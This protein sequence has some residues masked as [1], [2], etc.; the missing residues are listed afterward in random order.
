MSDYITNV[1][2]LDEAKECFLTYAE[3]VL[4]DR[5]IPNAED[6]LLS[7][8]RK[9]LWTCE[10]VLNLNSKSKYKKSASIVGSTLSTSY[11]HGDSACYGAL[12]KLAQGY[13]MRY[14]LIDGEGNL[15]TQ[16]GNGM[17]ASQRYTNS[18]PSI[19]ADLLFNDFKKNVVPLKETYNGEYM[20]PVYLPALFPNAIVNG[21]EAIGLSMSHSSLP[22][23]LSEVCDGII[24]TIRNENITIDELMQYIK[25]PDFPLDNVV[26]NAKDIK[27]NFATG[28]GTTIKVRGKYKVNGNKIIFTSIPYRTYRNKIKEQINK[29]IDKLEQYIAD[30]DDESNVGVN[31]LVFE[32]KKGVTVE[33]ALEKIFTLTDLQNSVSYNM[34]FIVN[35]TPKMCSMIDLIKHYINHQNN[36]IINAASYDKEKAEKRILILKGLL[37]AVDKINEVIALIKSSSNKQDARE[38]LMAF[39]DI[40]DIQADAILE[41]KLGR[42]TKINK[43][44][45]EDELKEKE[46]LVEECTKLI[47]DKE[48]RNNNLIEKLKVLKSKYGDSRRTELLD[49]EQSKDSKKS[50]KAAIEIKPEDCV[51]VLNKNGFIKR[52][53]STSF[54]IQNKNGKGVKNPDEALLTISATNTTDT[55]MFFTN[56]GKMYK[57]GV[58]KI[59]TGTKIS[60]GTNIKELIKLERNEE[61]LTMNSLYKD[62]KA[63]YVV[64]LTKNGLI[65]KTLLSEYIE[66]KRE[67][68][69][70]AIKFKGDDSLSSVLFMNEEELLVLTDKGYCIRFN[71]TEVPSTGRSTSGVKA[72]AL[73]ENDNAFKAIPIHKKDDYLAV[74]DKEGIAKKLSLTDFPSQRRSGKGLNVLMKSPLIGAEMVD[75]SDNLLIVGKTNSICISAKDI[76]LT[77]RKAGGN[78]LIKERSATTVIKL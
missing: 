48:Y 10:E 1:D 64:F 45:L 51:V 36:V 74:V 4:T 40:I 46:I 6:G 52:V 67:S 61:I 39:L 5:S 75:D 14:P 56:L 35:G 63:K 13:L 18:K 41:M 31:K 12:C 9:I 49:I 20:E 68:G 69:I 32:V 23:N 38:K 78:T 59:P 44:E 47:N 29:N 22:H 19:Y 15:G 17:E 25:G 57:L 70:I 11:F 27:N 42:L 26:I 33:E 7:V 28:H 16:E 55:M 2:I 60:K 30:F 76:Q 66:A 53:P 8:H 65:K 50:L 73:E 58:N 34:N 3:E 43:K 24:A 77:S 21:R 71:S 62:T 54:K 72:I 37:K